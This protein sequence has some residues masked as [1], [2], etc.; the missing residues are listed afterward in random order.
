MNRFSNSFYNFLTRFRENGTVLVGHDAVAQSEHNP[1]GTIYDAKR[2]IGRT[3]DPRS[4]FFKQQQ[5]RYSFTIDLDEEGRPYF[6]IPYANDTV[7]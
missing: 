1:T 7:R 2:F 6:V 5:Q 4:D 3:F